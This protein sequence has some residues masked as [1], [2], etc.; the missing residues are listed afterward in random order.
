MSKFFKNHLKAAVFLMIVSVCLFAVIRFIPQYDC[1]NPSEQV[2]D[3]ELKL[4]ELNRQMNEKLRQLSRLNTGKEFS[5]FFM[6]NGNLNSGFSFYVLQNGK[7]LF[8]S[9]N[10]PT[11]GDSLLNAIH[12]GDVL[13]LSNGDFLASSVSSNDKKIIGLLIIRHSYEYENKYLVNNFNP[14]LSLGE[15]FVIADQG[16]TLHVPGQKDWY[17]LKH[18]S[19]IKT[20]PRPLIVWLYFMLAVIILVA[21]YLFINYFS[22]SFLK[23]SLFIILV[24]GLRTMM[25]YLK[26]P[27]G[28]YD[29]G[30]FSPSHF[31]SSFYF[32]SLGDMLLNAG[33]ILILSLSLY[34]NIFTLRKYRFLL[35]C[36]WLITA[37]AIHLLVKGLVVDSRISFEIN[38]PGEINLFSILA[39]MSISILLLSFIFFTAALLKIFSG[40][41]IVGRHAWIGILA[42]SVYTA[43]ALTGMNKEKEHETRKLIA[44]KAEM[45]QDHVAEYLFLEQEDK[46]ISD[47]EIHR[48]IHSE[49]NLSD[50]LNTYIS[51]KYLYGYLAKF[52]L[53]A[54]VFD[55]SQVSDTDNSL[56]YYRQEALRGKKTLSDR[57]F[58]LNNEAGGTS[59]LA[60]LPLKEEGHRHVLVILLT[61]G[62]LHSAKGFPELFISGTYQENAST[63][64]YSVAR[65]SGQSLIYEYGNYV[66]P[67]NGKEFM[68]FSDQNSFITINEYSHLVHRIN[69]N[70]FLVISKPEG[71]VVEALTLFSWMFT[72]MSILV[73]LVFLL[74]GL[75]GDENFLQ[76]N[77]TRRVQ[78]SVIFLVVL[79]FVLIGWGTVNY[80]KKKYTTDQRKSI[81]DQVNA[82]WFLVS[83]SVVAFPG[84][85]ESDSLEQFRQ[86]DRI[87]NNTNI[88]FNIYNGDG[89]IVYSSQPKIF[90][91]GIISDRMNPRAY[92]TIKAQGLT[93][94]IHPEKAG[95]LKFIAA[96]APLTDRSGN[97]TSFLNLP[98]FEKQN[99]L[100]KDVSV[101]L[102]AL[103]NI[104]VLL[105]AI[106]VL[107]T[108]F[109]STRISKP[110]LLI[111]EKMSGIKLGASNEKI[112]YKENDEI[113]QLVF[114]YNR[115]IDELSVSAG[116]LARSERETAW[117]EMARQVA[118]EIKN[119]LTP[120]KLSVQHLS[121][122]IKD[123]GYEDMEMVDRITSMLV[124]QIETL[125][126]IATAFSN[127]AKMPQPVPVKID[128]KEIIQ[129]VTSLYNENVKVDLYMENE[130]Y[131]VL[132]DRDQMIS[133]FS[134][135]MKNAVQAIPDSG[136][137]KISV[138]LRHRAGSI[139]VEIA[140]NGVGIPED[141]WDKIFIPNF[142]TKSSGMGL[143]LAFVRNIVEE[144]NGKVWFTSKYGS[145]SSFF[146]NLPD[147]G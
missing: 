115:M 8:W 96:Y 12:N 105:F 16:D 73:F 142:T 48:I 104:Y 118:H 65:Y 93:Q 33:L 72:F 92:L 125:S 64:K 99:D 110:L 83:K 111:Q 38:S 58:L 114:E 2:K 128:L 21:I 4:T 91:K 108:V 132:A 140:D 133:V 79:T 88:D 138:S 120:M 62:F 147:A 80:I 61:S 68:K 97:I 52:E 56:S 13:R 49:K 28:L 34:E 146:V 98:Y 47:P 3:A 85:G 87:V 26:V 5:D 53:N 46:L 139:E 113:G 14:A 29:H 77:L 19:S 42:C 43:I 9:D 25:I 95:L 101:F 116:K 17:I 60:I 75:F 117:R 122:A 112:A 134:N 7:V 36:L 84:N 127:F 31:A 123:K 10:E 131:F 103:V 35:F 76:W 71:T 135:L 100:N 32:N 6:M 57:L 81:S 107:I 144:A 23:T 94:Y 41:R 51:Q 15:D 40:Y 126:N 74:A 106:A 119:P 69:E 124:Q 1:S 55:E 89:K 18:D 109:L 143:G 121:R 86:F 70:S 30:I 20:A 137:G 82:L 102:S 63:D 141:Q 50:G 44:Q 54:M 24:L 39:F 27:S 136:K 66:F 67:L 130:T 22:R 129:Q 45:G 90:E 78:A 11:A 145:G 59:Y 37:V